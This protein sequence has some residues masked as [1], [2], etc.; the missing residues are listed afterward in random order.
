MEHSNIGGKFLSWCR[1]GEQSAGEGEKEIVA[2]QSL[3][4]P[5]NGQQ[6]QTKSPI[7]SYFFHVYNISSP[8]L[9][10]LNIKYLCNFIF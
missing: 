8:L 2:D 3:F 7:V 5:E 9:M 4:K 1:E 10:I 6:K